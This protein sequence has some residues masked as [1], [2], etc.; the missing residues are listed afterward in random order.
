MSQD[1]DKKVTTAWI[2][3]IVGFFCCFILTIVGIVM[4]NDAKKQGHPGANTPFIVGIVLLVVAFVGN[5]ILISTGMLA[6]M[7]PGAG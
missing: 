2:L 3:I 4:A 1:L 7:L 6:T 5:A